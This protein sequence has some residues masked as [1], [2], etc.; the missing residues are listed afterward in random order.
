MDIR[1]RQYKTEHYM[2]QNK[3]EQI[4]AYWN[5]RPCNLH[6]SDAPVGTRKYFDAV[7]AKRYRVEPHNYAFAN[8]SKWKGAKV[9]EIGCGIGTDAV[10]FARGGAFYTGIELSDTSL[11]IAKKRFEV[12][13][14]SGR[15]IH[16]NS[17]HLT[18]LLEGEQFDLI[19]SYGVIHHSANPQVIIDQLACHLAPG[20]EIRVMLYAKHSWKN[21]LIEGGL[22]QPEAQGG[23]P[24]AVTYST[25]DVHNAFADF[26][27]DIQQTFIFPWQIEPYK[28]GEFIL[29]PYFES[30]SDHMFTSLEKVLGWNL[31]I[32]GKPIR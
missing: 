18:D 2:K 22:A 16:G 6:H 9:L 30:M 25:S 3:I 8:F 17:E 19:Y 24:Q 12:Y 29:E 28:K 13:G 11:D 21:A 26:A 32:K 7:E 4:R 1:M 14:Q 27:L 31:L 15:F 5:A 23:C 20:G 10:N